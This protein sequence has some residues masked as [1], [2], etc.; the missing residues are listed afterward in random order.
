MAKMSPVEALQWAQVVMQL[1]AIGATTYGAIRQAA[2]DAGWDADDA[3][4]VA[5]DAEYAKRIAKA[6]L[7][8]GG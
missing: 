7:E 1:V 5:L 6:K 8:A 2:M 3:R 4:L